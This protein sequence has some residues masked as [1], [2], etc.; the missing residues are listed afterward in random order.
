MKIQKVNENT[1]G[2]DFFLGDLHGCLDLL[3]DALNAV[4]F[5]RQRDRVFSVGDLVDRGPQS[6]QALALVFEPWFYPVYGNHEQMMHDALNGGDYQLWLMNGGTWIAEQDV[7]E[8]RGIVNE[9]MARLP[10]AI[11]VPVAGQR[12]GVI[13]SDVCSGRWGEFFRDRDVWCRDRFKHGL[14]DGL[15]EGIDLVVAGHSIQ[16]EPQMRGN[17]VNLDTGAFRTGRLTLME[18]QALLDWAEQKRKVA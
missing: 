13:H 12:V 10:H 7:M 18:A 16:D 11:E 14:T 6:Y 1:K 9:V 17:V 15:I 4:N 8:V 5:D 3:T 2:R